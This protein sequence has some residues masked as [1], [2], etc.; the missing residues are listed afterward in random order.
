MGIVIINGKRYDSVTGLMINDT[1]DSAVIHNTEKI[2]NSFS[3]KMPSWVSSYVGESEQ[4]FVNHAVESSTE[5]KPEIHRQ[6]A[7]SARR[8]VTES[9]TLNRRFVRKPLSENGDYAESIA[10]KH[11]RSAV[12]SS[13][14]TEDRT[15]VKADQIAN[16]VPLLTRRQAEGVKRMSAESKQNAGVDT[17]PIKVK[18]PIKLMPKEIKSDSDDILNERLSQLSR[19]LQNA[20]EIDAKQNNRDFFPKDKKRTAHKR[21]FHAPAIFATAS[22]AAVLVAVG[23]YVAMPSVSIKMAASKVGID[24][25][26]PYVPSGYT[27]DSD[28]AYQ[29]GRVTINYRGTNGNGGYSITQ[30]ANDNDSDDM[31]AAKVDN[32]TNGSYQVMQAGDKTIYRYRDV[33][34]WIQDGI[35]YTINTNN[36]LDSQQI[37]DIA[38]S[39]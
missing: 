7:P 9:R 25:K 4:S 39:L 11:I 23:V 32:V 35:Q 1:T 19:V 3:D 31:L 2:E 24:A 15:E 28:V 20:Q 36:Y 17:A 34:T 37:T 10:V 14:K 26:N 16:F 33:A 6:A 30:E 12:K 8:T 29:S 27:I 5:L 13:V 22:A 21:R 18:P 38:N